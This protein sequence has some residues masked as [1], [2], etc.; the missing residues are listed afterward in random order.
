[1]ESP[2]PQRR[3]PGLARTSHPMIPDPLLSDLR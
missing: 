2:R 3:N 1:M